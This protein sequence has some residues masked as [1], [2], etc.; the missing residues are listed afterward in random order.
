M[1]KKFLL[2]IIGMMAL[3][4]MGLA[5]ANPERKLTDLIKNY[6]HEKYPEYALED[7]R[8]SFK[9]GEKGV[10]SLKTFDDNAQLSI[11]PN[12]LDF[13]PLGNVMF[14]VAVSGGDRSDKFL[15]RAKVEAMKNVVVS[16]SLIKKG[17]RIEAAQ[18]KLESRDVA[19][20]PQNYFTDQAIVVGQK[21]SIGIPKN[22]T[23]FD[24][25][26]SAPMV[27]RGKEVTILV[28]GSGLVVKSQGQALEDGA[29]NAEIKVKRN[30]SLKTINAKVISPTEVEVKL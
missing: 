11:I 29:Q 25:M 1:V 13:K 22:S 14:S 30:D 5:M 10:N 6:V 3:A 4:G 26:V 2:F 12:Y 20:L 23:L 28:Y 27:E 17:T 7:I 18:L 19:L 8:V 15:V 21:A 24:W 16:S 9:E